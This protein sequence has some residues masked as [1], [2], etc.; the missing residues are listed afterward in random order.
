MACECLGF[1]YMVDNKRHSKNLQATKPS[2]MDRVRVLTGK[3]KT[4]VHSYVYSY[5][6]HLQL[7]FSNYSL[8]LMFL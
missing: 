4:R 6:L 1:R 2:K 5:T 3:K 8:K 7:T